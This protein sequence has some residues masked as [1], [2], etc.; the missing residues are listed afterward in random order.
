VLQEYTTPKEGNIR[1]T[2]PLMFMHTYYIRETTVVD[3]YKDAREDIYKID[4]DDGKSTDE[5]VGFTMT[6]NPGTP[7]EVVTTGEG[8]PDQFGL[9]QVSINIKNELLDVI[10]RKTDI[11]GSQ[12]LPGATITIYEKNEDGSKGKVVTSWQSDDTAHAIKRELF[13]DGTDYI[14][15]ETVA[16]DGYAYAEDIEFSISDDGAIVVADKYLDENGNIIMKDDITKVGF[17]KTDVAGE[18]VIG[19]TLTIYEKNA[20]GSKGKQIDQWVSGKGGAHVVEGLLDVEQEYILEETNAP[21]GYAYADN[22]I[23]VLQKDGTV[24]VTGGTQDADATS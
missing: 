5:K 10:I 8:R 9:M 18:E 2:Y 15:E 7:E 16:P 13:E 19:A 24:I 11:T 23:F 21:E 22:I 14:M 20:N 12:E 17:K 4:I 6:K 1:F 3:G